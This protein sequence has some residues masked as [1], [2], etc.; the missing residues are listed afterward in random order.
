MKEELKQL[1][2]ETCS[3]MDPSSSIPEARRTADTWPSTLCRFLWASNRSLFQFTEMIPS[4][5]APCNGR[6]GVKKRQDD[7]SQ[8]MC[9][10]TCTTMNAQPN[11]KAAVRLTR[12]NKYP[13]NLQWTGQASNWQEQLGHWTNHPTPNP[14]P[15][16]CTGEERSTTLWH[17]SHTVWSRCLS[18]VNASVASTHLGEH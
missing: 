3:V 9:T 18:T 17:V 2:Y 7:Y 14:I 13:D 12:L 5:D 4:E 15:N 11:M 10:L 6:K 16:C 1:V 8:H